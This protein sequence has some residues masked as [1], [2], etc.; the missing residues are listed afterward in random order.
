MSGFNQAAFSDVDEAARQLKAYFQGLT[1]TRGWPAPVVA[2]LSTWVDAIHANNSGFWASDDVDQFWRDVA[3]EF[4][5]ELNRI[6]NNQAGDL[7]AVNSVA[8]VLS[9]G[10]VA[11]QAVEEGTGVTGALNV[12]SETIEEKA[13]DQRKRNEQWEKWAP[14]ALPVIGLAALFVGIKALK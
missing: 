9:A 7:P 8:A 5:P 10:Q 1:V 11:A 4:I 2:D 3:Q 12:L 13:A 14:F 6:T